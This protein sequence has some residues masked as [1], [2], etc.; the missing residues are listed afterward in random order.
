MVWL[1]GRS[2]MEVM[3]LL[4]QLSEQLQAAQGEKAGLRE[5]VDDV[6]Q[7]VAQILGEIQKTAAKCLH[8]RYWK[9]CSTTFPA[10]IPEQAEIFARSTLLQKVYRLQFVE[11]TDLLQGFPGERP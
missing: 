11:S 1:C 8:A 6:D 9:P 10:L 7:A 2:R 3:K 4:L 5:R